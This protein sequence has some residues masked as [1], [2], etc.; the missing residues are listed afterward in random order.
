LIFKANMACTSPTIVV[1]RLDHESGANVEICLDENEMRELA[2][3]AF[4][5]IRGTAESLVGGRQTVRVTYVDDEGDH[6]TLSAETIVDALCF[7]ERCGEGV[8]KLQLRVAVP[9]A[10]IAEETPRAALPASPVLTPAAPAHT[11]EELAVHSHVVCDISGMFPIV[12]KRYKKTGEDYDLCEAEFNKLP[13]DA[14]A[15][16]ACIAR[17]GDVPLPVAN[18]PKGFCPKGHALVDYTEPHWGVCD[19]CGKS[20]AQGEAVMDCRSCNWY[21]CRACHAGPEESVDDS[22]EQSPMLVMM[23]KA[24]AFERLLQHPDSTVREAARQA[25]EDAVA[26]AQK[27]F[28]PPPRKLVVHQGVTCDVSGLCPI[29]GVR[30]KKRGEDY[31]LCEAEFEKL[32]DDERAAFIRIPHPRCRAAVV[33][34]LEARHG[35]GALDLTDIVDSPFAAVLQSMVEQFP[36]EKLA[37]VS[38]SLEPAFGVRRECVLP[39]LRELQIQIEA[40]RPAIE[41]ALAAGEVDQALAGLC[42]CCNDVVGRADELCARASTVA[43]EVVGEVEGHYEC[44]QYGE[45]DKNDWH[46]VELQGSLV[47]AAPALTWSNRA[48]VNWTLTPSLGADG[49]SKLLVATDCPYFE[50]GHQ[51]C[52]I[53]RDATGRV[54]GLLGPGGELYSRTATRNEAT[55]PPNF[56]KES[57]HVHSNEVDDAAMVE[58]ASVCVDTFSDVS[59]EACQIEQLPTQMAAVVAASLDV[60]CDQPMFEDTELRG[61]ATDEFKELLKHYPNVT[62]AY[63][64]GCVAISLA[65]GGDSTCT[66]ASKVIVKNTGEGPWSKVSSL[67]CV[68]GPHHGLSDLMLD[69]VPAG[70]QVEIVLDLAIKE[71]DGGR[72]AWAMCD[73]HGE[74]FGPL[75]LFE[76]VFM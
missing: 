56:E 27:R 1:V 60:G 65:A 73:D 8:S 49:N 3:N 50:D 55:E 57:T 45:D 59:S 22:L 36:R 11:Q 23:N 66:V 14:K 63:R 70:D 43:E 75:L 64:L 67:R 13:E 48:G 31:D 37:E 25:L 5:A 6:C 53:Q 72:S 28:A 42:T 61:D 32:T 26:A 35:W 4:Q 76:T 68:A 38:A 21:L 9:Q 74:P 40:M 54:I 16:F 51:V 7:A 19:G 62:Q 17:P 44:K 69:A 46:F 24:A 47:S 12:G 39:C 71:G 58:V 29:V 20:V 2:A 33:E 15:A 18:V 52:E 41:A 10:T 30:Y 34:E